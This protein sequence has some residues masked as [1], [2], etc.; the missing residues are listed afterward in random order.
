MSKNKDPADYVIGPDAVI[1]DTDLDERQI[2]YRGEQ[3]TE[4]RAA[5]LGEQAAREAREARERS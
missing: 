1:E 5:E 3:L 2:Y 4:A